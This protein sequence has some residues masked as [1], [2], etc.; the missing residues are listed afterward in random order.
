MT[1]V[2]ND[3]YTQ[4]TYLTLEYFIENV[5]AAKRIE[6]KKMP[7]YKGTLKKWQIL[8]D[9]GFDR[10][11]IE[12]IQAAARAPG[13]DELEYLRDNTK[14]EMT[15]PIN[16]ANVSK[17]RDDDR[18]V[19]SADF[20]PQMIDLDRERQRDFFLDRYSKVKQIHH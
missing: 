8:D 20:N 7:M 3:R 18:A 1:G 17:W 4:N 13:P 11:Q 15:L 16:N 9:E 6:T 10:D 2:E 12:K 19:D 14:T 5:V